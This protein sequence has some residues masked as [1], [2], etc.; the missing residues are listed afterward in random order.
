MFRF[1]GGELYVENVPV[2]DVAKKYGT[3]VYIYSLSEIRGRVSRLFRFMEGM[4]SI[5]L[6]AM[7]A[8]ANLSLLR[9]LSSMGI[10]A[11]VVS[12]GELFLALKA[13][14]PPKRIVFN[15]NGKKLW[16]IELAVKNNILLLNIENVEEVEIINN[17]AGRYN[18]IIDVGFRWNPEID[19]PTHP[20]LATA[21]R[22]SKFGMSSEEIFRLV[23]EADKYSNLRIVALHTH[24]GSQITTIQP[25]EVLVDSM[26]RMVKE[27]GK[28]GVNIRYIDL[29]GGWGVSY[30]GGH[31]FPVEDFLRSVNAVAGREYKIIFEPGRWLLSNAGIILS[32]VL[33]MKRREGRNIAILDMGMNDF[34]R[35]SMYGA[36]HGIVPVSV[37]GSVDKYDFVGPI[38]E[39]GDVLRE[40]VLTYSIRKGDYVAV[41]KTGAYGFSM[42]SNYNMRLKPPEVLVDGEECIL[43][44]K[45]EELDDLVGRQIF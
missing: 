15:G 18:R 32:R 5:V 6:F 9:V 44:R 20:Y 30:D 26:C 12:G 31:E 19:V 38:C 43:V 45:R 13:G 41:F 33:Y 29:G 11:D 1:K 3:P 25:Y 8:N 42:S 28:C 14:V 34:V 24:I 27:V 35:P 17:V 16:E 2:V 7:K 40:N 4:D 10:G 36:R 37:V 39:S 23:R 22:K 21:L